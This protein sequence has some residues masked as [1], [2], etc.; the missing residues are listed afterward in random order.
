MSN[1]LCY[2]HWWIEDGILAY[3]KSILRHQFWMFRCHKSLNNHKYHRNLQCVLALLNLS[4]NGRNI[5]ISWLIGGS[6]WSVPSENCR[7]GS[8]LS[9]L[10]WNQLESYLMWESA[11]QFHHTPKTFLILIITY[12][13]SFFRNIQYLRDRLLQKERLREISL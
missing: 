4:D 6:Y 2:K 12:G 7:S 13:P 5:N 10:N 8:C 1:K 3:R 11:S 9:S